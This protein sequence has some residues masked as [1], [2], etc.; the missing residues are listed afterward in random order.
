MLWDVIATIVSGVG[1]AGIAL[2]IVKLSARRA[3]RYLV[4]FFAAAGM[5]GFQIYSEY[6]WFDHQQSLL[7]EGVVVVKA[8]AESTPWRPWS[9]LQPQIIRFI[10][11]D[12][13]NASANQ[14]NSQLML[15]TLYLFE[16]RSP[17][18]AVKQVIHCGLKHRA[19]FNDA[20]TIPAVGAAL[21][22]SWHPISDDEQALLQVCPTVATEKPAASD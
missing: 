21:D 8:V 11:L 13:K 1:A 14:Q 20:L 2:L 10:A 18:I 15:A 7:P 9:Y 12:V 5:L 19:D 6:Q 4:P 3:P 22:Q 16:R 17:A